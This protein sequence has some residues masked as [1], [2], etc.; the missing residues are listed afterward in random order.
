MGRRNTSSKPK[1]GSFN[2]LNS[3]ANAD[4]KET[5]SCLGL[6]EDSLGDRFFSEAIMGPTD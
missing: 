4:S 3:F 5:P 2:G 1:R 6:I